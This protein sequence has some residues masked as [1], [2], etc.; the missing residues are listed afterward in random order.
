MS[1]E[2]HHDV[3]VIGSGAGGG[4]LEHRLAMNGV[5]MLCLERGPLLPRE[6]DSRQ[7]EAVVVRAKCRLAVNC[8]AHDLDNLHVVNASVFFNIGAVNSSPTAI[9]NAVRAG[10]YV[11]ECLP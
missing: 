3:G 2:H 4:T 6:R 8:M 7:T 5:R 10:D 9:I 1:D 11:T